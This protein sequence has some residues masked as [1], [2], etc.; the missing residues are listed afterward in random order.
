MMSIAKKTLLLLL[1]AI[2]MLTGASAVADTEQRSRLAVDLIVVMENSWSMSKG[3]ISSDVNGYRFDA[4][5]MAISMCDNTY[6]RA[7]YIL[8]NENVYMYQNGEQVQVSS[9][10]GLSLLDVSSSFGRAARAGLL[11]GLM[12]AEQLHARPKVSGSRNIGEALSNAV[13]AL[14]MNDTGNRKVI[15]LV[16]DGGVSFTKSDRSASKVQRLKTASEEQVTAALEKAEANDIVV[17]SIL[18]KDTTDMDF[19]QNTMHTADGTFQMVY[20]SAQLPGVVA[21]I[22]ADETGA[23]VMPANGTAETDGEIAIDVPSN[24]VAEMNILV[25]VDHIDVSTLKLVAPDGS[26]MVASG[27]E[28]YAVSSPYYAIYK[29]EEPQQGEW[30]LCFTGDG[31]GDN[32][33]VRYTLN[34]TC[35]PVEELSASS[36]SKGEPITVTAHFEEDGK[37]LQDE[38]LYQ[39][40]ATV[41]IA[42]NGETV[43]TATMEASEN[44]YTYT[45]DSLKGCTGGEYTV[46]IYFEGEGLNCDVAGATFNITNKAPM[47]ADGAKDAD[48]QNFVLNRPGQEETY[49]IQQRTWNLNDIVVDLDG[50]TLAWNIDAVPEGIKASINDGVL[51]VSTEQNTPA[52]GDIIVS[53]KGSDGESGPTLT[54]HVTAT[55]VEAELGSIIRVSEQTL[56]KTEPVTVRTQ[57]TRNGNA[58]LEDPDLSTVEA[59]LTVTKDGKEIVSDEK[60]TSEKGV[61]TCTLT[62]LAKYGAGDY[63]AK[64]TFTCG[65]FH[66][67]SDTAS[68]ELTDKAPTLVSGQ[69]AEQTQ[70]F[71]INIPSNAESYDVQNWVLD[72]GTIVTDPDGDDLTWNIDTAP[73]GIVVG[74]SGNTLT[75]ATMQNTQVEGD[76]TLSVKDSDEQDGPSVTIHVT[77][78][79]IESVYDQYT[80]LF[81]VAD[82]QNK[83]SDVTLTLYVNDENGQHISDDSYLPESIKATV[84]GGETSAF[85]VLDRQKDGGYSG[86][87]HSGQTTATYYMNA[88]I[89]VGT[90]SIQ[91]QEASFSTVD[92]DPV[93]TTDLAGALPATAFLGIGSDY[94]VDLNNYFADPDGDVLVY[95]IVDNTF[96]EHAEITVDGSELTFHGVS[97]NFCMPA[98]GSFTVVVTDTEGASVRSS[99]VTVT[100]W[101]V[102]IIAALVIAF[103]VLLVVIVK[104]VA[105]KNRHFALAAFDVSYGYQ[106]LK[107]PDGLSDP[108][109]E[110][111]HKPVTMDAYYTAQAK[112][113]AE[114][115]I[116]EEELHGVVVKPLS[117]GRVQVTFPAGLNV[118]V[119]KDCPSYDKEKQAYEGKKPAPKT[120][121]LQP[122]ESFSLCMKEYSVTFKYVRI[123]HI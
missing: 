84:R 123:E 116:H 117:N 59:S 103:V 98:D 22:M 72:L 28:F 77:V 109:P 82:E 83:N 68:F 6:S 23:Y 79:S 94:T 106:G 87:F 7:N 108:L 34:Y 110:G 51:T 102:L 93:V 71:E 62:D 42:K 122:G 88:E 44:G 118:L 63:T 101:P 30:L 20:D 50:D 78:V 96:E 39:I 67:E 19:F 75:V 18:L 81:R 97:G 86:I 58:A 90:K 121:T 120:M 89:T 8:F 5:A 66:M 14:T 12:D 115:V 112:R 29:V 61:Y 91:A 99:T 85:V 114:S 35:E 65:S 38:A 107:L 105:W 47:L 76:V 73:D 45:F 111:G 10:N 53:V 24:A 100:L 9:S 54:F 55:V 37:A 57:L 26:E 17:H 92:R 41:S 69:V 33:T 70:R 95:T 49:A 80:A 21:K 56:N 11:D 46:A 74:I 52:D 113:V 36:I 43:R 3:N 15:I 119:Y 40:P 60:M 2:F 25:P 32:I 16:A 64:V 1:T 4:A 27:S 104:V 31:S 13:D 48:A